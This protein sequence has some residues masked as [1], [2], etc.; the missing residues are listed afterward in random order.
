M[1][2]QPDPAHDPAPD[3]QATVLDHWPY[4]PNLPHI[5]S[6]NYVVDVANANHQLVQ[7][8]AARIETLEQALRQVNA[9]HSELAGEAWAIARKA[10]PIFDPCVCGHEKTNHAN[11]GQ[12]GWCNGGCCERGCACRLFRRSLARRPEVVEGSHYLKGMV[13]RRERV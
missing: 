13:R 7:R 8:H 4:S 6:Y 12:R 1:T 10:L 11:I 9:L 5:A 2:P 3:P